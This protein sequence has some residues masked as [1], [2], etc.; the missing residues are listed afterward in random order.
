MKKVYI[1]KI[2]KRTKC[3]H[4]TQG[5]VT[6]KELAQVARSFRI[7][8]RSEMNRKVSEHQGLRRLLVNPLIFLNVVISE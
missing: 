5:E 4:K 7:P 3:F 6:F 2:V 1:Q 8:L